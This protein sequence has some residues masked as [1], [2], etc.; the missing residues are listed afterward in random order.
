MATR[1]TTWPM[2]TALDITLSS[3]YAAGGIIQHMGYIISGTTNDG[4]YLEV[5]DADTSQ[6]IDPDYFLDTPPGV[7]AT[8]ASP[9]WDDDDALPLNTTRR[10]VVDPARRRP[11]Q[12]V[13]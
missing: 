12:P 10:F 9:D 6:Y 7:W 8:D 1:S 4:T 2:P 13:C 5:R 3:D 11:W